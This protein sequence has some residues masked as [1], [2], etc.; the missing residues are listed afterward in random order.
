MNLPERG[1]TIYGLCMLTAIVVGTGLTLLEARRRNRLDDRMFF[2]IAMGVAG[3][4]IGAK[5]SMVVFLGPET[6]WDTR[7]SVV[8]HGAAM[9]GALVG[10]YLLTTLAE[11]RAGIQSCA[12]DL[13]AP[14]IPLGQA[15]G[16][17]GNF[18][19]SDAY[20]SPTSLPWGIVQAGERRHPAA[21][22][23]LV[24]DLAL[25]G[26]LFWYRTRTFRDGELFRLYLL[27]YSLIRFPIEFLRYQPTPRDT[28]GLT[29]VQWMCIGAAILST[30]QL[31]LIRKGIPCFCTLI[32]KVRVG[33]AG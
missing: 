2:V 31:V 20:G 18:A 21:L 7:E 25:F 32:P 6:F 14:F 16:R 10:G 4:F 26:L 13:A 30:Y 5:L 27:G 23:E 19:T 1:P 28:F 9:A 11:W 22:Y 17:I 15:I 3:G 29:L 12:G 24:L 33:A 8:T